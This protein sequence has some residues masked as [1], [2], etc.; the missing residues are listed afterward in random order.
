[1]AILK[2]ER[3]FWLGELALVGFVFFEDTFRDDR[4]GTGRRAIEMGEAVSRELGS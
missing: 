3:G 1:M 2:W 4:G